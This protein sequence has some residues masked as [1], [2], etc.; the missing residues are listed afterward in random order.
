[1]LQSLP[2]PLK[3]TYISWWLKDCTCNNSQ[4]SENEKN[5]DFWNKKQFTTKL[6]RLSN[7]SCLIWFLSIAQLRNI[8]CLKSSIV[9]IISLITRY[10]VTIL[11]TIKIK[12]RRWYWRLLLAFF[13]TD[14]LS[15]IL[16]FTTFNLMGAKCRESSFPS[17]IHM[18]HISLS[19]MVTYEMNVSEA[20]TNSKLID[21]LS[22]D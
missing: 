17:S 11:L 1:M 3:K 2:L 5:S 20:L 6:V 9:W 14:R 8:S 4:E 12:V 13:W 7:K 10:L 21:S 22:K 15:R 16:L 18:C 19:Y